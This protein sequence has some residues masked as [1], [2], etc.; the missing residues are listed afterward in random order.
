MNLR[1]KNIT[2]DFEDME[3]LKKLNNEAFPA[4]ERIETGRLVAMGMNGRV[5]LTA[6]YDEEQFVGFYVVRVQAP[7]V[8]IFFIAIDGAMRSKGYG[9]EILS[10]IRRTYPDCQIVLDLE[11][12]DETAPNH[13][14]RKARK[15]FYL[16]NGFQETG[17]FMT[18]GGLVFE[19]M[20]S[21]TRFDKDGF[22]FLLDQIKTERFQPRLFQ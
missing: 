19:I 11:R 7:V 22:L 16:R 13:E 8:Y 10:L 1:T 14:Q 5:R 21:S 20:C 9:S 18:Y 12:Q 15:K 4:E 6:V 2:S 3:L 17:Y